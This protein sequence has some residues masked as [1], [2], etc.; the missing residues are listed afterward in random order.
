[1]SIQNMVRRLGE[2]FDKN[3]DPVAEAWLRV[4]YQDLVFFDPDNQ[5][6]YSM[7]GGNLEYQKG[8]DGGW[9]LIGVCAD[10]MYDDEPFIIGDMI[11]EMIAATEQDP[12]VQIVHKTE[13]NLVVA[14][15]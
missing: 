12:H 15:A 4:K 8:Q 14:S 6:V 10:D 13:E 3:N 5:T 2:T 7:Y 1:M 9:C 11:I